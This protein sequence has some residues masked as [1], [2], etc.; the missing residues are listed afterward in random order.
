MILQALNEL[1]ERENLVADPD[2]EWKPVSWLVRIS[3]SGQLLSIEDTRQ[4][5]P[6]QAG[7]KRKP[8][9]V[10]K[11][12]KLPREKA[13]QSGDRS[14]FLFDKAEYVFGIDP[15]GQ[16]ETKKLADRFYLFRERVRECRDG[17]NDEA[18]AAIYTALED[19][20]AVRQAAPLDKDVK[21]NDLFTFVFDPDVDV[22]VTN[23]PKVRNYWHNLRAAALPDG[24]A[25]ECLVTGD[26]FN[27]DITNFP[28]TK[29][30]PGGSGS[31][32]ALVSFNKSAFESYGWDGNQNAPISRR[33]AESCA[34][35]LQRLVDPAFPSSEE[36]G[37][38]L[39]RRNLKLGDDTVVCYWASRKDGDSFCDSVFSLLEARNE[40]E[41]GEL[42]RAIWRGVK[43]LQV[44]DSAFYAL[45]ISGQQGRMIVRDW[46]ESTV[47]K[48]Q[49]NLANYF[50]DLTIVR[51]TRP[52]KDGQLPPQFPL[53]L[54]LRS[55]AVRGDRKE[56]PPPLTG[57]MVR[58]AFYGTP[59]PFSILQRALERERAEI[60]GRDW[61]D[62]NRRDARAALIKAVL[63]R[64]YRFYPATT[65]YKEV[66]SAM[67]P[68]NPSEGYVLGKMMAVLER[69]QQLAQPNIN[70]TIVDHYFSSA[71]ASPRSTFVRLLKGARY[72]VRKA[73]DE[74]GAGMVFLLDRLLDD[75][76]SGFDV[77]NNGFPA[78]LDLN[79]QGLFV[80]GYHQMR[81]WLWL[82]SDEREAWEKQHA[83]AP[84]AY[85]W[86]SNKTRK[87][88]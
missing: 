70:S 26:K 10:G 58:A 36:P 20:A 33:A 30:V 4:Q 77:K 50:A 23:R 47:A 72:H 13:R 37:I 46:L 12:F 2:Y 18:V 79:Q 53:N 3:K 31:G 27:G 87:E 82:N 59:F 74:S 54:L 32:I 24:Q 69:V 45:V 81:H 85:L 61:D 60:D 86:R 57:Q 15:A 9:L 25:H 28:P 64:Q 34:T 62:E 14:F 65:N 71:S 55:L 40:E 68:T 19:V 78:H 73:Q 83:D 39:P 11:Q 16:R 56:I 44:E 80:L 29:K 17:T 6:Q 52:P 21:S 42:Y 22:L 35:A 38:T 43:P 41:V 67:D 84:T 49:A 75:M 76:S 88:N 7:S 63:N 5:V 8:R 66:Q 51:N 48:A 1:A